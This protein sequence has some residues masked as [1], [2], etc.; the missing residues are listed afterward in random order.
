MALAREEKSGYPSHGSTNASYLFRLASF[1]SFVTYDPHVSFIQLASSGFY[2]AGDNRFIKCQACGNAVVIWSVASDPSDGRYHRDTCLYAVSGSQ[3]S[4][5]DD[6]LQTDG[7][8]AQPLPATTYDEVTDAQPRGRGVGSTANSNHDVF[9]A[10]VNRS[11]HHTRLNVNSSNSLMPQEQSNAS[12]DTPYMPREDATSIDTPYIPWEDAKNEA[13]SPIEPPHTTRVRTHTSSE[14]SGYTSDDTFYDLD[15]CNPECATWDSNSTACSKNPG[16]FAY[17]PIHPLTLQQIPSS[18]RHPD[19]ITFLKLCADLTVRIN[20]SNVSKRRSPSDPLHSKSS[21]MRYGTGFMLEEPM[22][23]TTGH[24]ATQAAKSSGRWSEII[25]KR[26]PLLNKNKTSEIYISTNRHLVFDEMEAKRTVV[27][28]NFDHGS[29]VALKVSRMTRSTTFPGDN[30]VTLVCTSS[31]LGLIQR[32]VRTK[33]EIAKLSEKFPRKVK[34]CMTKKLFIIHH[35]HG[36]DK[37]LSYGDSVRVMYAM[38]EAESNSNRRLVKLSGQPSLAHYDSNDSL[39]KALMY[40][41]DTCEGSSGAPVISFKSIFAS[42]GTRTFHL[43]IWMHNGADISNNL[44]VSALKVYSQEELHS[45]NR[46]RQLNVASQERDES[47]DDT[48]NQEVSS[49]VFKVTSHPSYPAYVVHQKRLESF[50]NSE[51]PSFL[52]PGHL[53][54]AGFFYAGYSDCVR[55][56]QCGLGLRSWKHGDDIYVEHEKHRPNC[57]Y[58]QIQQ[59]SRRN[60]TSTNEIEEG[61]TSTYR[62]SSSA[63]SDKDVIVTLLEQENAKLKDQL[64]CK[65]CSRAQIKDLFLPC[66]DLYAC[67]ECSRLLTHCPLCNKQILATVNTF[68]T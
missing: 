68:F 30:C 21:H 6:D 14:S 23:L 51:L 12:I 65:V 40:A 26:L 35:P 66:G 63:V 42:G 10:D 61:V 11:G 25:R 19:V 7:C 39:S 20:I 64:T 18:A 60:I 13:I 15:L 46:L 34:E 54:T 48:D 8:T 41:A 3:R 67:S 4:E 47:D 9:T 53:A 56:F 38:K 2:Y 1:R 44:G 31:D 59:K 37:V 36:G 32:L 33:D 62:D 5:G 57:Q 43:D 17:F 27:E 22:E 29:K 49:P 58:L 52:R 45:D 55:C 50:D 28:F 24:T 16:H